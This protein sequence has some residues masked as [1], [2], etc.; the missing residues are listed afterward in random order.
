VL[1]S[2][3][4]RYTTGQALIYGLF[5]GCFAALTV[6]CILWVSRSIYTAPVSTTLYLLLATF[7]LSSVIVFAAVCIDEYFLRP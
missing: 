5:G 1:G 6:A 4:A 2:K 3:S 7:G